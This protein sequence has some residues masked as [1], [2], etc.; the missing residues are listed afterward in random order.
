M[1]LMAFVCLAG[2]IACGG[3]GAQSGSP[4]S[5]TS[6]G[7]E[8]KTF[9]EQ[10]A[11]GQTLYGQNCASCHGGSGEGVKAPRVV[12]LANGALPL[13]PPPS[14]KARKT[15][16]KTAADVAGFVV[17]SMPP[18]KE[19]SLKESEYFAILAFDLHANGVDLPK[20]LD[21][22]NAKDVVLHK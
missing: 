5:T 15:Q 8:P 6:A 10:V 19:G 16:F 20:K 13:D 11:L 1:R 18:G 22:S 21:G 3:A 12:G 7:N 9:E 4:T 2:L 14:A 17:K